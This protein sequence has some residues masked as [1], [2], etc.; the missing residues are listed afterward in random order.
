[1]KD[2]QRDIAFICDEI[3]TMLLEKNL[4]YGDSAINPVRFLSQASPTEQILVR[5]DDKLSRIKQGVSGIHDDEDVIN[6]LIGYFVLLKICIARD[7]EAIDYEPI[8]WDDYVTSSDF[9]DTI[10]E[11]YYN[12]DSSLDNDSLS[13]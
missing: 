4:K 12:S 8:N 11:P 5:I 3:K 6:D 2:T 13:L 9:L 1:M 7:K 10:P